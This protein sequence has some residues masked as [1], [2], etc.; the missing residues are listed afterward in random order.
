LI[1]HKVIGS[2]EEIEGICFMGKVQGT[3]PDFEDCFKIYIDLEDASGKL[4]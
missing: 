3:K 1:Q 2:I 4:I